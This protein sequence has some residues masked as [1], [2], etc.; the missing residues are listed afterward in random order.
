MSIFKTPAIR[1][2]GSCIFSSLSLLASGLLTAQ[3]APVVWVAQSMQRVGQA[4]AAQSVTQAQ[5]SAGKG[6][7]ESFQIVVH[8]PSSGLTNVNVS[9]STLSGPGGQTI[10]GSNIALFREQYVYVNASS[11][12]WGGSNQPMGAGW[13]ADG[14]IPFIDPA[15]GQ[16][17]TS[18]SL[19]AVP[20]TVTANQ[21]QPI[22]VD[23]FVPRNAAAGQYTGTYTVTS[24]Q[25][26]TSG[27]VSLTVWNFTLPAQPTLQS[28]FAFQ[29]GY[30]LAAA[31]E[32]L[33]NKVAPLSVN[34]GDEGGLMNNY[35][36]TTQNL[37]FW[38]GANVSNCSMSAAPSVSQIQAAVAQQQSGLRLFDYSADEVSGCSSLFST[39][40]QWGYNLHQAGVNNLVTMAP[41]TSLFDD[42]S[43]T[44]RSAVDEWVVLS[45]MYNNSLSTIQQ[46]Q[47]KGDQV[48][49]YTTLV[50]DPYTPKWQID[51]APVNFRI[52]PGF[53]SQTFGLTG[54]LYW[55]VDLWNSNEWTN[56][57]T[58]GLFSSAN[59]P[60]EGALVYPGSTVGV[61]GVAP[62]MRLKWIRDGVE[63]YEY[64]A[65]MKKA[66][67]GT[68]A[69]Q[70]AQSVA[71]DW[72]NWTR[73]TNAVMNARQQ[74]GQQLDALGGGSGAAPTPTPTPTPAPAPAPAPT[75]GT[76]SSVSAS[77]ASG[78]GMTQAFSFVYGDT[79]GS[80]AL[81]GVNVLI[82][83]STN[84]TGA[85]WIYYDTN[86]KTVWLATD[87][88][89]TWNSAAAGA[90]TTLSN[91]QC[92][93]NAGTV[94][95]AGSGNNLTLNVSFTFTSAFAGAKNV[96]LR[97]ADQ[98]NGLSGFSAAGTWTVAAP[99][100]PLGG[101]SASPNSGT[102]TSQTFQ[103]AFND[104]N[105]AQSL[106]GVSAQFATSAWATGS[107]WFYFDTTAKVL[108]LASD[109]TLSWSSAAAGSST[110]LQNSQC[111]I[112]TAGIS[113]SGSGTSYTLQIPIVFNGSF[114]GAKNI[115]LRAL[116]QNGG[117]SGLNSAG[118][119]NV[120]AVT[121]GAMA[122]SPNSG[123]GHTQTFSL[124]LGDPNGY[125][126]LAGGNLLVGT[127]LAGT[128]SCW[129]YYDAVGNMLWLAQDSAANWSSQAVGA[130]GTLAN[131][132][133]SVNT[134]AVTVSGAGS[135][136]TVNLPVTFSSSFAGAKNVYGRA[137]DKASSSNF[138]QVGT[139]TVQ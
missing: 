62:S 46:A 91:S 134:Q 124:V 8:A 36:L 30:S 88:A 27:P 64:V 14:L 18:A 121:L 24:D 135:V 137:V 97:A 56:V 41:V 102:G 1:F 122:V 61:Q 118:T 127:T 47:Q 80:Q 55:R 113:G 13:Y 35:G 71:P 12:N 106:R 75:S 107:C 31:Q 85:C 33:R 32:L 138:S 99:A 49:S 17:P 83:S 6:E 82:N 123:S 109:D 52:Q 129:L 3:A 115:Y 45:S 120:A 110:T 9:V 95:A 58:A 132:Q 72:T 105:G 67:Q 28:S 65:L 114:A 60:G 78:T 74:L 128:S 40:K 90:S 125:Q 50:Q 133:C 51:F 37:G 108:W 79:A 29:N 130:A 131:S 68:Q 89:S 126:N 22:W 54:I 39:I 111:T 70:V 73:D 92:S 23:V 116:D 11:P 139:W 103:F 59:Y 117:D 119:W 42:G 94:S 84:G 112:Q 104:P 38:S 44:G 93:V 101:T 26:S 4:D 136:L 19:R 77:P 7:Y 25:G 16:A 96:Y 10:G 43:G 48:W 86:A 100:I 53:L 15:T 21:N 69:L 57:N 76:P 5:I 20:F 2:R 98:T 87:D 34:S 81:S 63:D 66:G